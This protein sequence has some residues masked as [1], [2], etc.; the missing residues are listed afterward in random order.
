MFPKI[1]TFS[2]DPYS[3]A[4]DMLESILPPAP[5]S[6]KLPCKARLYAAAEAQPTAT[7]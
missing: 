4:Y 7:L 2:R 1:S 6:G 5:H 3:E